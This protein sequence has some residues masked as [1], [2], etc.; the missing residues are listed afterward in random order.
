MIDSSVAIVSRSLSLS[1]SLSLTLWE[2]KRKFFPPKRLIEFVAIV[3]RS[4]S[5]GAKD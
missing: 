3:S 1:L 5:L 4:L 2:Y